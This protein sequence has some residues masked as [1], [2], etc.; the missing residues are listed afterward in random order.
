M[1]DFFSKLLP[2]AAKMQMKDRV[3]EE[4]Q[5]NY[6]DMGNFRNGTMWRGAQDMLHQMTKRADEASRQGFES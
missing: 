5:V 4:I 1:T 6:K 2:K 3:R